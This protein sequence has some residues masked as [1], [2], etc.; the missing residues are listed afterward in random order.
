[1][2]KRKTHSDAQTVLGTGIFVPSRQ[3]GYL[4]SKQQLLKGG[5]A[6]GAN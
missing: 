6:E 2:L 3:R 1:M 4:G 5:M